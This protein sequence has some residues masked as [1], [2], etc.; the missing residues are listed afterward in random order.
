MDDEWHGYKIPNLHIIVK[1][2]KY[3]L[4]WYFREFQENLKTSL[5]YSLPAKQKISPILVKITKN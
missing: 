2:A 1:T 4:S 5:H 3:L